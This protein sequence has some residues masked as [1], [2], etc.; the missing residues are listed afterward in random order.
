MDDVTRLSIRHVYA[1]IQGS[2]VPLLYP[3]LTPT[4]EQFITAEYGN[5][6]LDA[7][8]IALG[9]QTKIFTNKRERWRQQ[10]V[11]LAFTELR[12]LLPTYP[13]DKKLSKVEI[14]RNAVKYIKFLDD[15]LCSMDVRGGM[16]ADVEQSSLSSSASLRE[17]NVDVQSSAENCSGCSPA[18]SN[19]NSNIR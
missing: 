11:N 19:S 12:R 13:P 9:F 15:L 10:H 3:S 2:N 18:Y 5:L 6:D 8:A 4:Q 16:E 1:P 17:L 14:L 7:L